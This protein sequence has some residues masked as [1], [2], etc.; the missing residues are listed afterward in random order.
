MKNNSLRTNLQITMFA[1]LV[2]LMGLIPNLGYLKISII[3][4]T[5]IYIPV[6]IGAA[7]SGYRGALIL[8]LTFGI[9]SFLVA[10]FRPSSPYDLVFRNPVVSVF[11]R[12]IFPL[13][14]VFLLKHQTKYLG[15]IGSF[16]LICLAIITF[17]F[18]DE[19]LKYIIIIIISLLAIALG[20]LNYYSKLKSLKY[21]IPTFISV[22][23]NSILV[24]SL[25]ALHIYLFTDVEESFKTSFNSILKILIATLGSNSVVEIILSCVII[26]AVMKVLD[27]RSSHV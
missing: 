16:L 14:F 2:L 12:A 26:Q 22:L 6:L 9:S 21:V 15:Y 7:L 8:G 13:I 17:I 10:V 3:D 25:M 1:T 18:Y 20:F 11:P 4:V 5:I 27:K 23:I 24:L 19:S